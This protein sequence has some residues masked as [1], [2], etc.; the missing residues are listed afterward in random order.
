[1]PKALGNNLY[2]CAGG[3]HRAL[4]IGW[5]PKNG[6]D[7]SGRPQRSNL[8]R[9][10]LRPKR[11]NDRTIRRQRERQA[12][13]GSIRVSDEAL[14]AILVAQNY[15]CACGCGASVLHELHWDHKIPLARGGK[16][17][18]GNL[19]AMTPLCNLRKAAR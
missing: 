9:D 11:L 14:Q 3:C 4:P 18:K 16:H 7:W 8:C 19:Q 6:S 1:M 15:Q 5:F 13:V 17:E 12:K 10:C 2:E